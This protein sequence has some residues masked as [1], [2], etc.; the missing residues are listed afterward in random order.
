M[1]QRTRSDV[2]SVRSE[3]SSASELKSSRASDIARFHDPYIGLVREVP[4]PPVPAPHYLHA[5]EE[6]TSMMMEET[7]SFDLTTSEKVAPVMVRAVTLTDE[8]T[9]T[10]METLNWSAMRKVDTYE[11]SYFCRDGSV[12]CGR[13]K[14]HR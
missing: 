11:L 6:Q 9:G 2:H 8:D 3:V 1:L 13:T 12:H 7:T 10:G 5:N 14:I 4:T